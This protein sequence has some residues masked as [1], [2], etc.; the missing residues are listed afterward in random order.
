MTPQQIDRAKVLRDALRGLPIIKK[1]NGQKDG[2]RNGFDFQVHCVSPYV[3]SVRVDK[4][5]GRKII[6]AAEKIIRVELKSLSVKL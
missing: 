6:A 5:T 4:V 2:E 3:H 1:W